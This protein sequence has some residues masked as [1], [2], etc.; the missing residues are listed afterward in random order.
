M[1][2][3]PSKPAWVQQLDASR[4]TENAVAAEAS[5]P[6]VAASESSAGDERSQR[7]AARPA[8]LAPTVGVVPIRP[9]PKCKARV[10][11]K[12]SAHPHAKSGPVAGAVPSAGS[13]APQLPRLHPS[14]VQRELPSG[15]HEVPRMGIG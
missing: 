7:R 15:S 14:R 13:D 12:R 11:H 5:Q 6:V 8:P 2:P 1:N 10:T 9:D 3:A 4:S